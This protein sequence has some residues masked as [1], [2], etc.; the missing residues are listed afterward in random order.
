MWKKTKLFSI[1]F[2]FLHKTS[3]SLK[4]KTISSQQTFGVRHPILRKG[5]AIE[6]CHFRR[7]NHEKTFHLGAYKKDKIIG[8]ISCY[9]ENGAYFKNGIN[10]QIRGVAVLEKFQ[11]KGIGRALMVEAEKNLRTSNCD[12]IWLNARVNANVFYTKL[13]YDPI[14]PIF[15]VPEIGNHQCF[16]KKLN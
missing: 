16:Y 15:N 14:G 7:D 13:K 9:L 4:I 8:V 10:Y 11:K 6:S 12:F 1:Y 5:L 3:F 2:I